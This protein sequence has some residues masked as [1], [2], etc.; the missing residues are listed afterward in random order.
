MRF[1]NDNKLLAAHV[2]KLSGKCNRFLQR[3]FKLPSKSTILKYLSTIQISPGINKFIFSNLSETGKYLAPNDKMCSIMFDEMSI[4]P[5]LTYIKHSGH[6]KGLEEYSSEHRT[7]EISS[8]VLIFMIQGKPNKIF[9]IF[10]Y[11]K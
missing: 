2:Y 9:H 1:S 11:F 5:K 4:V 8:N 10:K 3:I 6:I 7:S